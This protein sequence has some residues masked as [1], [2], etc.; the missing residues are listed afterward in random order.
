MP[1][2]SLD[3]DFLGRYLTARLG[4]ATE[5]V[6]LTKYPR[7]V[8]RETWFVTVDASGDRL[9]LV[10]R[11]DL[12][13]GSVCPATL[14]FEYEIYRR[15]QDSAV[16]VAPVRWYEDDPEWLA[17]GREFYVRDHIEGTWD[18]PNVTDPRPE[19]D[20]L[21][22]AIS[23]EHLRKLALVHTADWETL[24]FGEIMIVPPSPEANATTTIDRLLAELAQF[25]L[26][27]FPL[28]VDAAGWLRDNA[29]TRSP[30]TSLL[31][32]TNGFGEEVFRDGE[33]V[34]MS[35]WELASLGD[36]TSD[37]AHVQDFI[38]DIVRDREVRWGLGPALEYYEEVS[39]LHVT[40]E[41][42][43]YYRAVGFLEMIVFAHNAAVPLV[44]GTDHLARLAWVSTE[45]LYWAKN[46]LAGATGVFAA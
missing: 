44:E 28:V 3:P 24:G 33:I 18:I 21:R 35:D 30:R 2:L 4:R 19:F 1:D 13:G 8:S 6:E 16:P 29:P 38:P 42:I 39:G 22:I 14:R 25:Q 26:E 10:F 43:E 12:P 37:F 7:G 46:L 36:P 15:L 9:P 45:V 41:A 17:G 32:G 23:K 20:D 11:R 31:K 40:T 34:A 5:I 27:P